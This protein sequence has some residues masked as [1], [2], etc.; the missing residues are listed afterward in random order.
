VLPEPARQTFIHMA[1]G[2]VPPIV[3]DGFALHVPLYTQENTDI[4]AFATVPSFQC[5]VHVCPPVLDSVKSRSPFR[6]KTETTTI[7]PAAMEPGGVRACGLVGD[8]AASFVAGNL[9]CPTWVIAIYPA[10][11]LC[12]ADVEVREGVCALR[13]EYLVSDISV[14]VVGACCGCR[15]QA[16]TSNRRARRHIEDRVGIVV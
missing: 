7:S 3:H 2:S 10:L 16:D 5:S 4:E 13:C 12:D 8:V 6:M 15:E 11:R 9:D 1:V 14:T